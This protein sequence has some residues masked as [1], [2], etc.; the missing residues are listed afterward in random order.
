MGVRVESMPPFLLH[1]AVANTQWQRSMHQVTQRLDRLVS[2][3][4]DIQ[5]PSMKGEE[6][7]DVLLVC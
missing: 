4:R 1:L 5:K 7:A 3:I 6:P 2:R